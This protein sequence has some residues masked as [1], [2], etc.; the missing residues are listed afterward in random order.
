MLMLLVAVCLVATLM[1]LLLLLIPM[2]AARLHMLLHWPWSAANTAAHRANL[3]ASTT[4]ASK[5]PTPACF[6]LF[7]AS[8]C[9]IWSASSFG[10]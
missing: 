2:V 7:A 9:C 5:H 3:H 6:Y 8:C 10:S 1:L 4:R